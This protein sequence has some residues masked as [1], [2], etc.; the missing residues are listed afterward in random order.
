MSLE[1]GFQSFDLNQRALTF[2]Y[3]I[4]VDG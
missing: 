3:L 4:R 2:N 1:K